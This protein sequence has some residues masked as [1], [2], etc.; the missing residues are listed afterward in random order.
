M[1]PLPFGPFV[2]YPFI[3]FSAKT[4][5]HRSLE[6]EQLARQKSL[7]QNL[8]VYLEICVH[9][10][11]TN[12][13]LATLLYY[14]VRCKKYQSRLNVID[15]RLYN[16]LLAGYA[17]KGNIGKVKE[18]M[19]IIA[20]DKIACVPQTYAALFECI[21]RL[22]TGTDITKLL[23]KYRSNAESEVSVMMLC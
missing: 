5:H 17:E 10:S 9:N 15:I 22:P 16:V 18:I 2:L 11:M 12:R 8:F 4:K 20:E 23:Q 7:A 1:S 19:A 3:S 13:G 14:R 6:H 21:G